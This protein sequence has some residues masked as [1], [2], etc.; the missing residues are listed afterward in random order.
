MTT[1]RVWPGAWSIVVL[2]LASGLS[3][4]PITYL[5]NNVPADQVGQDSTQW[6]LSGSVTTDGTIGTLSSVNITAWEWE[7]TAVGKPTVTANDLELFASATVTN[8]E[9]TATE[10]RIPALVSG[11]IHILR[12]DG[13]IFTGTS[14]EWSLVDQGED[15]VYPA[16]AHV[17]YADYSTTAYY[18]TPDWAGGRVIATAVPE[19]ATAGLLA[20][21]AAAL[22][23]RRRRRGYGDL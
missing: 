10:L 14:L 19:P 17:A 4:A 2:G 3:A 23:L 6:T 21:T 7:L 5:L 16:S 13:D 11:G 8:I 20:A 15:V 9:A 12:L 18:N 1:R 22:L